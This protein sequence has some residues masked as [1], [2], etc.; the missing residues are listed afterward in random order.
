MRAGP[1]ALGLVV[2]ARSGISPGMGGEVL[3][4][5]PEE[6]RVA[7]SIIMAASVSMWVEIPIQIPQPAPGGQVAVAGAAAVIRHSGLDREAQ[8]VPTALRA[9]R[10]P[11]RS[12]TGPGAAAGP[13]M[14]PA[15]PGIR[16]LSES[17]MRHFDRFKGGTRPVRL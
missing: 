8:E 13:A 11:P 5:G 2:K 7:H 9:L 15:A 3:I 4:A 6:A 10:Q 1:A 14:R 16:A 12:A 17:G